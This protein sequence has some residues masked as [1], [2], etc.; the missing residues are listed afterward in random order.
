MLLGGTIA[1]RP[2]PHARFWGFLWIIV[3]GCSC[4]AIS[5]CCES[6]LAAVLAAVFVWF[7]GNLILGH[8]GRAA[9]SVWTTAAPSACSR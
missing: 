5:T 6:L 7:G 3:G 2:E 1:S 4:S 9:I 8:C